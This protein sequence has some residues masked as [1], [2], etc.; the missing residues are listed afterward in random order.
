MLPASA[1]TKLKQSATGLQRLQNPRKG[2]LWHFLEP[3]ISVKGK[4][5]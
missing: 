1:K 5:K 3:N 4:M 2:I